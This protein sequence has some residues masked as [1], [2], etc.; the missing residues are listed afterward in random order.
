MFNVQCYWPGQ[1]LVSGGRFKQHWKGW[2]DT[3]CHEEDEDHGSAERPGG[4][5]DGPQHLHHL[6]A[7]LLRLLHLGRAAGVVLVEYLSVDQEVETEGEGKEN[8]GK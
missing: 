4:G 8:G 7:L 6:P 5:Q 2:V 1:S 3:E